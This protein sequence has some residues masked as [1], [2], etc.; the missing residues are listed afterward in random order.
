MNKD[1]KNNITIFSNL[2]MLYNEIKKLI[3]NNSKA[4]ISIISAFL[5]VF[6][7][8]SLLAIMD[9][10]FIAEEYPIQRIIFILSTSLMIMGLEIGF[11]KFIFNT[12]DNKK[13]SLSHIFNYFH[14]LGKYIIGLL[15][16]YL[17]VFI[18]VIPGFIYFYFKYG[19]E[20]IA[21]LSS[22]I[23]DPYFQELISAYFNNIDILILLIIISIPAMYAS[24]RLSFWSYFVIE[25]EIAGIQ[26]IQKSYYLT[27]NK[28]L[29]IVLYLFIILIVNFLGLLSI[30]GIC[31]T[32]P[33]T[34][35]F[36]CKYYRVL[37]KKLK[38]VNK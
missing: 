25:K 26:A 28:E 18:G 32:I 35:I 20:F 36:L 27:K 9:T 14:L 31:F 6:L 8:R 16:F 30:I 2:Y 10:I 34:Y 19:T 33:I 11:T 12:L 29:E 22:S 15:L 23:G 7:I 4:F 38:I 37:N 3:S 21:I 13:Y 17:C 1:M 5:L 24:I